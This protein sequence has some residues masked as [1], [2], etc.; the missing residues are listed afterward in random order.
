[1]E[2]NVTQPSLPEF[3]E[4]AFVLRGDHPL[5]AHHQVLGQHVLPGMAY[6]DLLYQFMQE[7][8][9]EPTSMRLRNLAIRRPMS[10]APG[11]SMSVRITAQSAQ[12]GTW[13]ITVHGEICAAAATGEQCF[14]TAEMQSRRS[15]M[16]AE[17][18]VL[19]DA[20]QT[21]QTDDQ[22]NRIA[23]QRQ[24]ESVYLQCASEGVLH[25]GMMVVD[26][27]I[28]DT[29]E[30][31]FIHLAL[32][33]EAG[34]TA[35]QT[36]FHPALLDAASLGSGVM[37]VA[38][39]NPDQRLFL[40]LAIAGFD[41]CSR[42]PARCWV[43]IRKSSISRLGDLLTRDI[44]FFDETGNKIAEL[45]GFACKLLP[46]RTELA[47]LAAST[48]HARLNE[49][50][51][52]AILARHM[53]LLASEID[54]ARGFHELGLD[55]VG[56]LEATAD[57]EK[58]TGISQPPTLLFEYTTLQALAAHFGIPL[59]NAR[60]AAIPAKAT[61]K[62][63]A[64]AAAEHAMP[65]AIIG[66]AG[67]YPDAPDLHVFWTNLANK[68]DAIKEIPAARW[69][70]SRFDSLSSRTGK[71][72]SHWGGFLDDA[73][74]FDARFF[75]I[76][77]LEAN[78]IDPQ[79]RLF[80]QT[81][82]HA[83]EDAGYTPETLVPA[84]GERA[85]RPVG[86]FVG[87]MHKDYTLVVAD[88]LA[89]GRALPLSLNSAQIANRL[90]YFCNFHGPSMT[91]DTLC[92]SSLTAVHLAVQSLRSGESEVAIAGGV[93]LALHP[94]KY[95]TYGLGNLFSTE[96][97]CKSFGADGDGYVS[98]E[99]VGAVVLK[100]L[101]R[102]IQD[103]DHIYAVIRASAVNHVGAVSGVTVP[104]PVAQADLI[105]HCLQQAGIDA[106][107]ISCVEAHGTG[108]SLGDPIEVEGLVKAF[109][110]Q[111]QD[112]QFC[113]LGS[114]K[115]N[116]GHTE[117]AAGVC[118][119]TKLALQLDRSMI[120]PSLHSQTLNAHINFTDSPFFVPQ[121][122]MPWP[123]QA[124]QARRGAVSSFGATGS[125]AHAILEEPPLDRR[126]AGEIPHGP[127][128]VPVSARTQ[129]QLASSAA[130]L[131]TWMESQGACRM[132]NGPA[133]RT[134]LIE[135]R[136]QQAVAS[137]LCVAPR[138]ID[139]FAPWRD[140]GMDA[141]A[142]TRLAATWAESPDLLLPPL[143]LEMTCAGL[144]QS[145]A[146]NSGQ[147]AVASA[148]PTSA[149]WHLADL[150]YT[151]QVGRQAFSCRMA[152]VVQDT[153]ELLQGLN[154]F[155]AGQTWP[156]LFVGSDPVRKAPA[157]AGA[158][159]N[160]T[161]HAAIAPE[162]QIQRI[163]Q[164]W[165]SGSEVNWQRLHDGQRLLR[166]SLPGYP[167]ARERHWIPAPGTLDVEQTVPSSVTAARQQQPLVVEPAWQAIPDVIPV[168]SAHAQA[169]AA[170]Q[171]RLVLTIGMDSVQNA[172]LRG[173]LEPAA[174][175]RLVALEHGLQGQ[176]G[177][178][179]IIAAMLAAL[180]QAT[181][182]QILGRT[183]IRHVQLVLA[184][185]NLH[186]QRWSLAAFMQ[187][188][189]REHPVIKTQTI[190]LTS[191][192]DQSGVAQLIR[193]AATR[194][195]IP[196]I[197]YRTVEPASA[198]T[199][200][201][202]ELACN[203]SQTASFKPGGVY[204]ITGGTGG[205]GQI[206]AEHIMHRAPSAKILL[207]GR[208]ALSAK[209]EA[210][211][212]T[213]RQA[214]HQVR[215][216]VVDVADRMAVQEL[217]GQIRQ[218][219]NR[220]DGIIHSAGQL[221][222]SPIVDK[223]VNDLQAVMAPKA[224]GAV[225]L[226]EMTADLD[227]DFFVLFS[228]G[229]GALGN[230]GQADYAC[231]NAFLD[232]FALARAQQVAQ[233]RRAGRT[234]S[235]GWPLWQNGG[236]QVNPATAER[237][238]QRTGM[239]PM[240]TEDGTAI[241][242]RILAG[243]AAH[244]VVMAG[245]HAKLRQFFDMDTAQPALAA[246]FPADI[247]ANIEAN[248]HA[249]QDVGISS[250]S[251]GVLGKLYVHFAALTG[252]AP[253]TL[254][255]EDQLE[256]YGLDSILI[257]QLNQ[258]LAD[259]FPRLSK[260]IW[261]ECRTLG[262][263]A[264][265][266]QSEHA[267]ECATWIQESAPA[268]S[269]SSPAVGRKPSNDDA[270]VEAVA[271]LQSRPASSLPD[272]AIAIIG[273]AG[274]YPGA[275]DL[276][277]FWDL[278]RRG[279]SGI[280]A[281]PTGRW[282]GP[283]I[284]EPDIERAVANG[285]S[286]C[287]RGGFLEDFA[288]FDPLFFRIS[289]MEARSMDPQER[290]FLESCWEVLEDAGLTRAEI[291]R[292]FGG[293]VGVFAGITKTGFELYGMA[294]GQNGKPIEKATPH[295]SFCSV[296]NRVSYLFD[297]HGPSMP[298]DTMCSSSAT[299]IH[300]ACQHILRDECDLAIAGGVNLYLHPSSFIRL[301][302]QRMLSPDGECRSFGRHANGFVPGEGVGTV[303]L[304]RLSGAL[305][306]G[307]QIH[308]VIRASHINHGGKTL[309]YTVP[310]PNAQRDLIIRT[311]NKAGIG[312]REVSY[313]EAHGTGTVLG[314]PIEITGLT[315]AFSS[316]TPD[317][318]FCSI[319]SV[320]SNIG[321][322]EAAAG[323][324]G[325]TKIVLQMKHRM[326]VPSLHA[327]EPNPNIP[328]SR[329]PF[330]VQQH[331]AA[332]PAKQEA[333]SAS[334]VI[335][336][337]SAFG[338]G[339]A[340]A[341]L[342][343]ES[344]HDPVGNAEPVSPINP[345]AFVL[346]AMSPERL[347][348][349][350]KKWLSWLD[351]DLINDSNL[352]DAA[353]TLQIGREEFA[354]RLGCLVTSKDQLQRHLNAVLNGEHPLN[355]AW[356][357]DQIAADQAWLDMA[358]PI[359]S[360]WVEGSAADWAVLHQAPRRRISLPTYPFER[361]RYWIK[362]VDGEAPHQAVTN[363]A[364]LM[365]TERWI[366]LPTI[367]QPDW[368]A[369]NMLV[370][371]P[372]EAGPLAQAVARRAGAATLIACNDWSV[373]QTELT[374]AQLA[375][376]EHGVQ[377]SAFD[378]MV[379]I[380]PLPVP[381]SLDAG[382]LAAPKAWNDS[383]ER[384]WLQLLRTLRQ[385]NRLD[386]HV[387]CFML[388]HDTLHQHS[389]GALDGGGLSGLAFA[390]AQTE[391]ALKLRCLATDLWQS[392]LRKA[393]DAAVEIKTDWDAVAAQILAQAADGRATP[394]RLLGQARLVQQLAPLHL[395]QSFPQSLPRSGEGGF[396]QRG[397]YV[398]VGGAGKLGQI[399]TRR[400][401]QDADAEV[402]WI[403]RR[404][405]DTPAV[406][407]ALQALGRLGRAPTYVQANATDRSKM[408]A[409]AQTI[410]AHGTIHGVLYL[411]MVFSFHESLLDA[412]DFEIAAV[413]DAKRVGMFNTLTSFA[414]DRLDF[415]CVFSS[416]QGF[417]FADARTSGAYAIGITAA[418]SMVRAL[419][420][421]LNHPVGILQWGFW[422]TSVR[423]TLLER[424]SGLLE[425]DEGFD[426]LETYIGQLRRGNLHHAVCTR[427]SPA[428]QLTTPINREHSIEVIDD[429][430]P[431]HLDA[432]IDAVAIADHRA[433]QMLSPDPLN[434]AAMARVWQCLRQLGLFTSDDTTVLD[435]EIAGRI[436]RCSIPEKYAAWI[437]EVLESCKQF[438][439][440]Q[441]IPSGW[442]SI[443]ASMDGD[444][445]RKQWQIV[446]TPYRQN[447]EW[448]AHI[449]LADA[450]LDALPR[451]LQGKVAATEVVFAG[452]SASQVEG[453]YRGNSLSDYFNT[454]LADIA[455]DLVNHCAAI[456]PD[457]PVRVIEIGAGTGGTSALVFRRLS[458]I[459]S[460]VHY[461]FTDVSSSFVASARERFGD[462]LPHIE[463][464]TWD[465]SRGCTT[466]RIAT[467][468]YDI[469]IATNVLHATPNIRTTLQNAKAALRPNAV[470]LLN[471]IN[472]KALL[473]T[474]TFGL[475]DGWW[476]FEDGPWR[477]PGSPLLTPLNW[478]RVLEAE[479]FR[480]IGF[481]T[482]A[483]H[484]LGQSVIAAVSDGQVMT[485]LPSDAAID[486]KVPAGPA[487]QARTSLQEPPASAADSDAIADIVID[488]LSKVLDIA[489]PRISRS[490]PFSDYGV[491]SIIGV[492]LV[493][494]LNGAL[495]VK[496]NTAI[497]YERTTVQR[498]ADYILATW[499]DL[500]RQ[501][502]MPATGLGHDGTS[503]DPVGTD[504]KQPAVATD[505][506]AVIGMSGQFPDADDP[507]AFW[508]N[509]ISGHDAVRIIEAMNGNTADHADHAAPKAGKI[510]GKI[511]FDPLF[512]DISPL[513]AEGMHRYQR[514]V[515]VESWRALEHAGINPR[516]LS[517]AAVGVFVG[518]EPAAHV[519]TSFTG[520]SD[521]II[522]SRI[523]YFLN[524]HGPAL[525]VNTGCSS[526]AVALHLACESLRRGESSMVLAGGVSVNL[527]PAILQALTR[528]G[529]LSPT[530]Q[531][532]TFDAQAD[533]TVLAEGV[534]MLVLKPL[535]CAL[536]DGDMIHGVIVASGMNQDGSSNGI[537]A[538]NGLAQE[539]LLTEVYQKFQID[540]RRISYIEAHGTGTRL[541]DPIEA[542]ALTRA[543]RKFTQDS[544]FCHVG[545]A[546]SHIGHASAASGAIGA[547]K[548][549]LSLKHRQLP[550]L[551]HFDRLNPDIEFDGS[552][553]K[554]APDNVGWEAE[555][556]LPR[557]AAL[558]AFG[559]SGTNV[560]FVFQEHV[561]VHASPLPAPPVVARPKRRQLTAAR[562]VPL[563][564]MPAWRVS[565]PHQPDLTN[566]KKQALHAGGACILGG[567]DGQQLAI[568]AALMQQGVSSIVAW[569]DD[570][571][572]IDTSARSALEAAASAS[573]L[574]WLA[575]TEVPANDTPASI[576]AQHRETTRLWQVV[577]QI[578]QARSDDEPVRLTLITV[579]T[580]MVMPH[581]PIRAL[582]AGLHGFIGALAKEAPG[583]KIVAVDLDSDTSW[584]AAEI[585]A[586]PADP[587]GRT[588]SL[589][590]G[591]W[592]RQQ[593]L[594]YQGST[595]HDLYRM[596]GVYVVIGGAGDIGQVWTEHMLSHFSA[597]VIWIG[598]RPLDSEIQDKLDRMPSTGR[599]HY[600]SAD[601]SRQES[602]ARVREQIIAQFGRIHGVVHTAVVFSDEKLERIEGTAFDQVLAAKV[603]T[604][605]WL[606]EVFK[607]DP[608]DFVLFFSS[609]VSLIRNPRQSHYA[610]GCAF[611]D[612]L[613]QQMADAWACPVKTMNWGYWSSRKEVVADK[614]AYEAY[615]RMAEIGIGLIEPEQGMQGLDAL[616]AGPA[617]QLA[618]MCA[619]A[620]VAI[621]GLS[622]ER[623]VLGLPDER[624]PAIA[625]IAAQINIPQDRIDGIV[626]AAGNMEEMTPYLLRIM[627]AQLMDLGYWQPGPKG[628]AMTIGLA[629]AYQR[630]LQESLRI[631]RETEPAIIAQAAQGLAAS[632][633]AWDR[634]R[635]RWLADSALRAQARL[636][637]TTL[638]GL[639]DV[640][641]GRRGIA[642]I[643]FPQ[644]STALVEAVHHANPI[645]GLFNLALAESIERWIL[646]QRHQN[647]ATSIRI[648]EIGAG[649]GGTTVMLLGRIGRLADVVEYVYTDISEAFL[650]HGR[651]NFSAMCPG[652]SFRRLD[653][654]EDPGEQGFAA[655]QFDIVVAANVL[656]A[657]RDIQA[658]LSN[659]KLLLKRNGL[660][661]L[662]EIAANALYTH[663]TFGLLD[664]WWRFEDAGVRLPGGPALSSSGW[665][666]ML[667]AAG[668]DSVA[669]PAESAH[670]L[671]QQL[672]A[673]E[674]NGLI[675]ANATG[676]DLTPV[677]QVAGQSAE[678]IL[679]AADG[680]PTSDA[681]VISG[682]E[683]ATE[684]VNSQPPYGVPPQDRAMDFLRNLL[685]QFLKIDP[686]A[687]DSSKP[688]QRYG[689]DSIIAMQLVGRLKE[690]FKSVDS[691]LFF[692]YQTLIDLVR[693]LCA[694]EADA[695]MQALGIVSADHPSA[696]SGTP[697]NLAPA[698]AIL[699]ATP[700][701]PDCAPAA[702]ASDRP[703]KV[704]V[705]LASLTTSEPIAVIG[706]ALRMP[707]ADDPE[708]FWQMLSQG[709][710]AVTEMP[711]DRWRN[712]RHYGRPE[713][714]DRSG[715]WGSFLPDVAR[716]DPQFF[717]IS[718][719]EAALID[720]RQ[721]I[722]LEEA[723]HAFED[724]GYAGERLRDAMCG[725]FVGVEEG[726]YGY[727]TGASAQIANSQS[728]SLAARIASKLNLRGPNMAISAACSS[729]LVA[730]HQACQ[731][732]RQGDCKMAA[733]GGVS[734]MLSPIVHMGLGKLEM[735]AADGQSH[736][737]DAQATGMVPGDAVVVV[738]LKLLSQ[739]IA[740]GDH[741]H[742]CIR[743]SGVNSDGGTHGLAAANPATQADLVQQVIQRAAIK[744]DQIGYAV[745][746]SVGSL[747]GDPVEIQ[748]LTRAFRTGSA[749]SQYCALGSSKPIFGH[750]F[751]ASGLVSLVHMLMS[752]QHQ[753]IPA[754]CQFEQANPHLDLEMSPFFAPKISSRWN[755]PAQG[756]RIGTIG[757]RGQNGANACAIIEEYA[758]PASAERAPAPVL[759][760][761]SARS[762]DRLRANASNL[763]DWIARNP[764]ASASDA[765][766]TLCAG[767]KLMAQR[768]AV[769][770]SS[771][772]QLIEALQQFL[773]APAQSGK[774]SDAPPVFAG[775]A[776][777]PDAS[778]KVL[779]SGPTGD[780][781]LSQCV[782]AG[783]LVKLA[784]LWTQGA[785]IEPEMLF[786][787]GCHQLLSLPGYAF[788]PEH[789]W[790]DPLD[791]P[792]DARPSP[793]A[794]DDQPVNSQGAAPQA[795]DLASLESVLTRI[796]AHELGLPEPSILPGRPLRDYGMDS[797]A[798]MR[799]MRAMIQ[800]WGIALNSRDL[801]QAHDVS[802]LAS[803]VR[804]RLVAGSTDLAS[805]AP[806]ERSSGLSEGQQGL[807]LLQQLAPDATAYL[808]PMAW[809]TSMLNLDHL[810]RALNCVVQRHPM[811]QVRFIA[812]NGNLAMRL[813]HIAP[814]CPL[815]CDDRITDESQ[816][817]AW[818]AGHAGVAI[819][820]ENEPPIR[821]HVAALPDGRHAL[822][823][824]VHHLVFD[825]VSSLVLLRDLRSAYGAISQGRAPM[826][827]QPSATYA[828]FI[829][830]E[831]NFLESQQG[832]AAL[833]YWLGLLQ[834]DLPTLD[835]PM[836]YALPAAPSFAGAAIQVCLPDAQ[837]AGLTKL[838]R[839]LE[840][841]PST[842]FLALFKVLLYRYTHQTDLIVGVPTMG[843]D[844]RCFE[845]VIGYFVN[846]M[847][848][849]SKLDP[850]ATLGQYLRML[851]GHLLD[852]LDHAAYPLPALLRKL[853]AERS[854][855]LDTL[856]QVSFAYQNFVPKALHIGLEKN[857]LDLTPIDDIHQAGDANL[858]LEVFERPD[859]LHIA[860]GYRSALF[861]RETAQRM[862]D[863]YLYL[864][865]QVAGDPERVHLPLS[866]LHVLSP[867]E[868][869]EIIGVWS[870]VARLDKIADPVPV[871]QQITRQAEQHPHA[872]ALLLADHPELSLTYLQL[873]Q[874]SEQ[875]AQQ[876]HRRGV[877]PAD[878]IGIALPRTPE[879]VA[880]MLAIFKIGAVYVPFDTDA[881]PERVAHMIQDARP[882]LLLTDT[883]HKDF[884]G[885]MPAGR[886]QI[887]SFDELDMRAA[888]WNPL[889]SP[890]IV[891]GA[892]EEPSSG[893]APDA[894]YILF[895]SGSTGR[896][897][898]VVVGHRAL[899][900][901]CNAMAQF[902]ALSPDDKILQFSPLTV[903]VSLEQILP[904]L[905]QG[906]TIVMGDK[907]IWSARQLSK[908]ID[909]FALTVVDLPP[910][911]LEEV[912]REWFDF[913]QTAP[914]HLPRIVSVGGEALKPRIVKRWHQTSLAGC[915][916]INIYGPTEAT[917]SCLAHE[918]T[919]ADQTDALTV[920]VGR[921]LDAG[922]TL[923]LDPLG[924][925]V[926]P[927]VPGELF[928]GGPRLAHGYLGQAKQSAR[929]FV[930]NPFR[931]KFPTM[932][933]RLYRTGDIA[934]Y[935]P[936]RHGA[937][938]WLGRTDQQIKLRGHRIE[939]GEIEAQLVRLPGVLDCVVIAEG[940]EPGEDRLVAFMAPEEAA[941]SDEQIHQFMRARLPA[942]M[943]P[944][945]YV[946]LPSIL[947]NASGKPD[948]ATLITTVPAR[949]TGLRM[950]RNPLEQTL[951]A[952][953]E[954]ALKIE[955]PGIDQ[956][957]FDMGGHSLLC[958][959]VASDMQMELGISIA[960]TDLISHPTIAALA[961][962]T[963]LP[964]SR[965]A[966]AMVR[967]GKHDAGAENF[968]LIHPAG[969][970]VVCYREL[971]GLLD[972]RYNVY[973]LQRDDLDLATENVDRLS[974]QQMA[975]VYVGHLRQ[976]QA[977][978][979]YRLCGWSAGGVIAYEIATQLQA[980]GQT[981]A[982]LVL[983][984]THLNPGGTQS[985]AA[986]AT[987]FAFD[988][989]G[990][991]IASDVLQ[992]TGEGENAA[993]IW[994]ALHRH[995][996]AA[997]IIA[998]GSEAA[999][1000]RALYRR[1001]DA[1002]V[1003]ALRQYQP[1004]PCQHPVTL[1005]L[1006]KVCF[1007]PAP[1008]IDPVAAWTSLAGDK[1009]MVHH[1010]DADHH[1011]MVAAPAVG[1012]VAHCILQV[1013]A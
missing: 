75:R 969:G 694:T 961:E 325:L 64:D 863:H 57:I 666:A 637:E 372:S 26:G 873:H 917:I 105:E 710:S 611:Q 572:G 123:R 283:S 977:V 20:R 405:V 796:I 866:T 179:E 289:P 250:G 2:N 341:H 304:K 115:S 515:L 390:L 168:V 299:A 15:V 1008:I 919:L 584:P 540:P 920:P 601:A 855:E 699:P 293:R 856:F 196:M 436:V 848:L 790:F 353:Y 907:A 916:L 595:S 876:F 555:H 805:A 525:V 698:Q 758:S 7:K 106:R 926:A 524:L 329:T 46:A 183:S 386:D 910:A 359:I 302:S 83:I 172:R 6:V 165:V 161:T 991:R 59:A 851:Q 530:G 312:A 326:L 285:G 49:S 414:H 941:V 331:C 794:A 996:E 709:R 465:I 936:G 18:I 737:F 687:F 257:T 429:A 767:R 413:V 544:A 246:N 103:G 205:L 782:A 234:V 583:W 467:G 654:E 760:M 169:V 807:W 484:P 477:I 87:V 224:S 686:S 362:Q 634:Q 131:L 425:D 481:P 564:M 458:A 537:T 379:L 33:D 895:T 163:A 713:P 624:S 332:W 1001:F 726:E 700:A 799:V 263:V 267:I 647:T 192:A 610:A 883:G 815:I 199:R 71:P 706:M 248:A 688:L 752:M 280:G 9:F 51:L 803:L 408:L 48:A 268:S 937:V 1009:L 522:A 310:N 125:N 743:A 238:R 489:A 456:K 418:D 984:D 457:R 676:P 459:G 288:A 825:G 603:D 27:R 902:F 255:A 744:A 152:L 35:G 779:T 887:V 496:L 296:A 480:N 667:E 718:P 133:G 549:L 336:G 690:T 722:F 751:A 885:A 65:I 421:A 99:G 703:P 251:D 893:L 989:L 120:A 11:Q 677:A 786:R 939:A 783:D 448:S 271:T 118:G 868:Q 391:P 923:I 358:A 653:I 801:A 696:A 322:L 943:R 117:A 195:D 166:I 563:L 356:Q 899:A 963:S 934:R 315:Q 50:D 948:R 587:R 640:L 121:Q 424:N 619:T 734:L 410:R 363:T 569:H 842:L 847:P 501:R 361:E 685:G 249:G 1000:L 693:H 812:D 450:C 111:T 903:D 1010:I 419:R 545:S 81:G 816:L 60:L 755:N 591:V 818:L 155:L 47:G 553:F 608:L 813:P 107:S 580:Q 671:G 435:S 153:T 539:R 749:A 287:K 750:T 717:E 461:T 24:L 1:L 483:A 387:A 763:L 512:F 442:R 990:P 574:I 561:A 573:W 585:L 729:G 757:T 892:V 63:T 673:G 973:G 556:G 875:L 375:R 84:R 510:T 901:H 638:R 834:G 831:R 692:E 648:L 808:V 30:A 475:L 233:G 156:G 171:D 147:P 437:G 741:I 519:P 346:S 82:W 491:D 795:A 219:W 879:T 915:R 513:E 642:E 173:Q 731:A 10:I 860:L 323:V 568:R 985:E 566:A 543:F 599:V 211:L 896:P 203:D 839:D 463:F 921:P 292:R 476:A 517:E 1002:T 966:N 721:R 1006:A 182:Q 273:I 597:S 845:D 348:V 431:G 240:T 272:E 101:A 877:R 145:L 124:E 264:A 528:I 607:Q 636:I 662:N 998:P 928:I 793:N 433:V 231:A 68:H 596:Q 661:I 684:E 646:A 177:A 502:A 776:D 559:H 423:G 39:L 753:Q 77:P 112:L 444:A 592:Y 41:A 262:A 880:A 28:H 472:Q 992:K 791:L 404:P 659:V 972:S 736:V 426:L 128:L 618:L 918:V 241:F 373:A 871:H 518:A 95:L 38:Q 900:L 645:S 247:Q 507:D 328:F 130:Q 22:G 976:V 394:I 586:L 399:I 311:L 830:W 980:Q 493:K 853:G 511:R 396:R 927:G 479:G 352:A 490:V 245:D 547:I 354:S 922:A 140:F 453:V 541:G 562:T 859:A 590:N 604:S 201:W 872:M 629:P 365:F 924:Q 870:G 828:D 174:A 620:D 411:G 575:T 392:R 614:S 342:L 54:P 282:P 967:L 142:L 606:R 550:G 42:L 742:G 202:R 266:L 621:E 643:M 427:I 864:L 104:S 664:G 389:Y 58:Q 526:S 695:M 657:T 999:T 4:D 377:T 809:R 975:A 93:N 243:D 420:P 904:G 403:G 217:I 529:M 843:R 689:V 204:L 1013:Q 308:A 639:G 207:A 384:G 912:L 194:S 865:E 558:S 946:W 520:A 881:A 498:L 874:R 43:R 674:S 455:F 516:S 319:G 482:V 333:T 364:S 320:K 110:R 380:A 534:A 609:L 956:N 132:D 886:N 376:L 708:S 959:R 378:C 286:Y 615:L 554:V 838:S 149:N 340:N 215:Y 658:T 279:E 747:L 707:G 987:A 589:R 832:H 355:R 882:A 32:G 829:A 914:R 798:T 334:G 402:F 116:V 305:R 775:N 277:A 16:P 276:R 867:A 397:R 466:Q 61:M 468:H 697:Q 226:D 242:E 79:E 944:A 3:F 360:R 80:M 655:G 840:L 318:G 470:L 146:G 228:S 232:Q 351:E 756:N 208:S 626:H 981:V 135:G 53:H 227:L 1005:L 788:A 622:R 197:W 691:T 738:V 451:I 570:G 535:A 189:Q 680:A 393:D 951:A 994:A 417:A 627:A 773:N 306:D 789:Y 383:V 602:L 62:A 986:S 582:H 826:L 494:Y 94:A 175:C 324:A 90:S 929:H 474:L 974:L 29:D 206:F 890:A 260:T 337:L 823:V 824:L 702:T 817:G 180:V 560:H 982:Q 139:P 970:S 113:A 971:A 898:G 955:R 598:R 109:R 506:I 500:N 339:G 295:T 727:L 185:V 441:R 154:A 301:S 954:R 473:G 45:A 858:T 612:A 447:A 284:F 144:A 950:P 670:V 869:A 759:F 34:K 261:F 344:F 416:I 672:V 439:F 108:T 176:D 993:D 269:D 239:V 69:D 711:P 78:F 298:I 649:T 725:V 96:G 222:D 578:K 668:F 683:A 452:G 281:I 220:L 861:S 400:L 968:F 681:G 819:D 762:T 492:G 21:N 600:L 836:D 134:G 613:A 579:N 385:Q 850:S 407:D 148:E 605:L 740:D 212:Q 422:R 542:N 366:D 430:A 300:E 628:A 398:L 785:R 230:P 25:T 997:G 193:H 675:D 237:W 330:S 771:L 940:P 188:L 958:L 536:A 679:R 235:I 412:D 897:K 909:D 88:E 129:D 778:L 471:E 792:P 960:L 36:L 656:H 357:S 594:P 728:A 723:W 114:A 164:D 665:Q 253:Q 770:A 784:L 962:F 160:A 343:I 641:T 571:P 811:L 938:Q 321:H 531:C 446:S 953:W 822:L 765:A 191:G 942:H 478:Q 200:R 98:A 317:V 349:L 56:L 908:H 462:A 347:K 983:L 581:Q 576:A 849:R 367:D 857:L 949:T 1004:L 460:R 499:P 712:L 309:G 932:G 777:L 523:S 862:L 935:L 644:G 40:P 844:Q 254:R 800:R 371:H 733:V 841:T 92:S 291:Q 368:R 369:K 259:P 964:S 432:I 503:A 275:P 780:A 55:S 891:A 313:I 889:D 76:M 487:Q 719:R 158:T 187:T 97:R 209:L 428:L 445:I 930:P 265:H 527:D 509:L 294:T 303:L 761:L 504:A 210:Q 119:L 497:L 141:H 415:Q 931:D 769:V 225:I 297:F 925:P 316:Q 13:K 327:E 745:A 995:A 438:G 1011:G 89:K 548:L 508:E 401:I 532:R 454:A 66:M 67:R 440:I 821:V 632:W 157:A 395:S 906:S 218:R 184:D 514:L 127:Y 835:I 952:I 538:P 663:L 669:L 229:A 965:S 1003:S 911:Y 137:I 44:D 290:L 186:P 350:V 625:R 810:Q 178:D 86:V 837:R 72:L 833:A 716:F 167:F 633:Q 221:H 720:P 701:T 533:G 136:L 74:C 631:L 469:V 162:A 73:D 797:L 746:H 91:I 781:F 122:L 988:L 314:D 31:L 804:S 464:R 551:L 652:L 244:T 443:A 682:L 85:R 623:P 270:A 434:Q 345:I 256:E 768:L 213:W 143:S 252:L 1007:G 616:L 374:L 705:P 979:P 660:L 827:P 945:V 190:G 258:A 307:D 766:Y 557:M 102:A 406:Q 8:G 181:Q 772:P 715:Y 12:P 739:A 19:P 278:L 170:P 852:G 126:P 650:Q 370:V 449:A 933:P 894:A 546:K 787:Q 588:W 846:L 486:S 565:S 505:A 748:A 159:P 724:A 214:G 388:L 216:Y 947:R 678:A 854:R 774:S 617:R 764:G 223:R 23:P 1012:D 905:C 70:S 52:R 884:F 806:A 802:S 138:D 236:M 630:W 100:P 151:M 381:Y 730:L 888:G 635:E 577:R 521:A 17:R 409:A 878:V 14:A 150:A 814:A 198:Q 335:A 552:P 485:A 338:A 593:L 651:Q 567:T 754:L 957:F 5:F 382:S 735:L 732:I 820:L 704:R 495:A 274:R 913:P 37:F 488:H 978:G 714:E